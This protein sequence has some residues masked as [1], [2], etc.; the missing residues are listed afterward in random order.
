MMNNNNLSQ[1]KSDHLILL[2]GGNP[3]PNAVAGVRLGHKNGRITLIHS[4]DTFDIAQRLQKW[5]L[6]RDFSRAVLKEVVENEAGSIYTAVISALNQTREASSI[7]LN[8]TGGTKAMSVH[9]YNAVRYWAEKNGKRPIFSYLDANTLEMVID[10]EYPESGQSPQKIPMELM[11]GI[12]LSDLFDLHGWAEKSP[13]ASEPFLPRTSMAL[14]QIY[15]DQTA[16]DRWDRWKEE[17]LRQ[18]CRR[19]DRPD[20]WKSQGQ[21]RQIQLPW[22]DIS[23]LADALRQELGQSGDSLNLEMAAKATRKKKIESFCQWLDGGYWLEAIVLQALKEIKPDCNLH[24]VCMNLVPKI[25]DKDTNFELDVAVLRGY[26]L[27]AISCSISDAKSLLKHKL[28][29]AYIRARQLGGDEARIALVSGSDDPD[30]LEREIRQSL[31]NEGQI[32]V[33]GREHWNNLAAEFQAW[34]LN[35]AKNT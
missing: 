29:E 26:Q 13:P 23:S 12:G 6:D 19:Q 8:Y 22:P 30:G 18:G 17:A 3:L 32:K 7:G 34:I 4:P 5:F 16:L 10:P 28:M 11:A 31:S 2:V 1:Y 33:F 35:S 24:D 21:L 15:Q 14:L 9:A 20:K 25:P 27:F